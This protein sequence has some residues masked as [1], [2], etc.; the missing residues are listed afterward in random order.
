MLEETEIGTLGLDLQLE[1]IEFTYL[2]QKSYD[3][4]TYSVVGFMLESICK[5]N[6]HNF[7][8]QNCEYD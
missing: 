3:R 5:L 8:F 1:N 6:V 2:F 4:K 7:V